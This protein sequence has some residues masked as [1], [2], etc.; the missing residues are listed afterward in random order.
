MKW[1]SDPGL[2]PQGQGYCPK[3]CEWNDIEGLQERPGGICSSK[4]WQNVL[5]LVF[6]VDVVGSSDLI[7]M[8]FCSGHWKTYQS[9]QSQCLGYYDDQPQFQQ[10]LV[11]TSAHGGILEWDHLKAFVMP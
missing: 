10:R 4:F 2:S 8:S 5:R 3:W 7:E 1:E 11:T 9:G 6:T